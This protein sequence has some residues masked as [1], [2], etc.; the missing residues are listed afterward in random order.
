MKK[1]LFLLI[2]LAA[3]FMNAACMHFEKSYED[4]VINYE[5]YQEIYATTQ[6]LNQD[7]CQLKDIPDKD[8]MFKN[9]FSKAER[10]NGI[11][12]NL[13]RWINEY[14]AKSKMINRSVWKSSALPYQLTTAEFN[15]YQEKK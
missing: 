1:T 15:C 14:N 5:E 4:A 7:L 8:P 6:K 13:N 9:G 2:V 10:L 11:K 12:T 3:G